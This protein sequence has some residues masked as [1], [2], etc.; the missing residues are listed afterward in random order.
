MKDFIFING[1][2]LHAYHGVM[3]HEAKVGQTF[4]LDVVL[5]ID[6]TEASRSDKVADTASYDEVADIAGKRPTVKGA[7]GV[8]SPMPI[9]PRE[10]VCPVVSPIPVP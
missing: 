4:K 6:L 8:F 9:F 1:L 3:E 7:G 5:H 10:S 2:S